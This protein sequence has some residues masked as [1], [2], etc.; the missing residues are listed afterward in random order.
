MIF[1]EFFF[2]FPNWNQ[3]ILEKNQAKFMLIT[4]RK[5][6]LI[7]VLVK[8]SQILCWNRNQKGLSKIEHSQNTF[9][10]ADGLGISMRHQR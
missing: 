4:F 7:S 5:S 8:N 1:F 3:A 9:E 10:I 6:L 2:H